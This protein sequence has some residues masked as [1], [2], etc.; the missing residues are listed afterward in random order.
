[1]GGGDATGVD[2]GGGDI[3][4]A[5]AELAAETATAAAGV[6]GCF[7]A[8]GV[9]GWRGFFGTGGAAFDTAPADWD[10]VFAGGLGL[11]VA[12]DSV[13]RTAAHTGWL[14][15]AADNWDRTSGIGC[16]GG[17]CD[18]LLRFFLS[19]GFEGRSELNLANWSWSTASCN[20]NTFTNYST[21]ILSCF[22]CL[23]RG[24]LS[25][26][27]NPY[28]L[29]LPLFQRYSDKGFSFCYMKTLQITY[30]FRFRNLISQK[31]TV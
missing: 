23:S 6:G 26:L 31:C 20:K 24:H 11:G 5:E 12:L 13:G 27:T 30:R 1:M 18:A 3:M 25:A 16:G 9:R 4:G 2:K 21:Y 19:S 17:G 7:F 29:L 14:A 22:H 10:F 28:K 15:L 8:F